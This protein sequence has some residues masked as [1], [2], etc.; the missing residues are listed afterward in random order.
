MQCPQ[1]VMVQCPQL[2]HDLCMLVC[3]ESE[4]KLSDVLA[5]VC[6]CTCVCVCAC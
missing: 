4:G 6:V 2:Q 5:E 1:V 3:R